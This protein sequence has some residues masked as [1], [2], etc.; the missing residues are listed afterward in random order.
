MKVS[1]IFSLI[2]ALMLF[3]TDA[4]SASQSIKWKFTTG[5]PKHLENMRILSD[6][7]AD[8]EAQG[9]ECSILNM[10]TGEYIESATIFREEYVP[11]MFSNIGR[12]FTFAAGLHSGTIK[13]DEV[14]FNYDDEK[15]FDKVSPEAL[16]E[17]YDLLGIREINSSTELLTAYAKLMS[18]DNDY[19]TEEQIETLKKAMRANVEKGKAKSVNIDG[20]KVLGVGATNRKGK[21][22]NIVMS[23][24]LGEFEMNGENYAIIT[25]LNEPMP[26]KSTYGFNSAGWNAVPLTRDII[27]NMIKKK[28]IESSVANKELLERKVRNYDAK[29]GSYII[30]DAKTRE[31][32]E[33]VFIDFDEDTIFSTT[34]F[35][36]LYLNTVGLNTGVITED[37]LWFEDEPLHFASWFDLKDRQRVL[38]ELD[39]PFS[40]YFRYTIADQL[41]NYLNI[42]GNEKELLTESQLEA[43]RKELYRGEIIRNTQNV[44]YYGLTSNTIKKGEKT[45]KITLFIGSFEA[46]DK[47]YGIAVLFDSPKGIRGEPESNSAHFNALPTAKEIIENFVK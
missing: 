24:F 4:L 2:C 45:D 42:I 38:K 14:Q 37:K 13:H 6:Y 17:L 29:G 23:A 1:K 30:V 39:L 9:G 21:N 34:S 32:I 18:K 40:P 44:K 16:N 8:F 41:K 5:T 19:L 46:N 3:A 27:K 12:L 35:I 28:D 47:E 25:V 22:P 33:K 11:F 20:V 15:K 7:I 43:I 10:M 36:N 31:P 26:R